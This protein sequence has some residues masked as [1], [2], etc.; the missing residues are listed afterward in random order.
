MGDRYFNPSTIDDSQKLS[1]GKRARYAWVE[2]ST[3]T[4]ARGNGTPGFREGWNYIDSSFT[5]KKAMVFLGVVSIFFCTIIVRLFYLQIMNGD[6]YRVLAENNRQRVIPIPAERGLIYDTKGVALTKNIPRFSLALIPQDLPRDKESRGAVIS[7][8]AE[9]TGKTDEEIAALLKEFGAYSYESIVIQENLDYEMALSIHIAASDL[10]GIYIQRGSKRLYLH[11]KTEDGTTSSTMSLSHVL[12]YEGKLNREE[13]DALYEKGYLPSDSIGKTG[14]EKT[15]ESYLRGVYGKKRIEVNAY[16]REQSSLA[17]QPPSPGQHVRLSID[18]AMQAKLEEIMRTVMTSKGK[19][20]GSGVVMDPR[21]GRIL[22]LVSLPAFDNNDFSGGIS[23]TKYREY[24]DN[25][26]RPLFSR[27]ISGTYPSG[28]SIKPTVA[29]AALSEGIITA[30]TTFLST[31]G[32][33]LGSWFFPDWRAGGHGVTDVRKSIADSVNTFYYYIGGGYNN[34]VGLGIERMATYFKM[35]GF[36]ERL[37]IDMP[38]E[39]PG[40][41]PSR[42][43]KLEKKKEQWY[44]GDNYNVSIGQ[45][46]VLVT[47]LQ[48]ASMTATIANFGTIYVPSVV[49]GTIDAVSKEVRMFEPQVLRKVNVS[50]EHLDTVRWGMR[51]C[52]LVGS[53]RQLSALPFEAS[54]KTGTAQWNSNKENHAWFTSFAPFDNPEIVVTILIEEG[55]EGSGISAP[56]AYQFYDWWWKYKHGAVESSFDPE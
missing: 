9:L 12:G 45:G 13:L 48:I 51:D 56:I 17:E 15:Y 35:F 42:E 23:N 11:G 49:E 26:D 34:F 29:I 32:L 24:M 43:W 8:L 5:N 40:F 2:D 36:S 22:A 3:V 47:P 27:A 21:N 44:V 16:G 6:E 30:K 7:R 50:R 20:R 25:P 52:V 41:I 55:V 14:V 31:G 46:D 4:D 39:A 53:C 10:P 54:G 19:V 33:R 1:L 28:S 38:G 18:V 37:G